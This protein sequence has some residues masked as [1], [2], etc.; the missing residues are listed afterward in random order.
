MFWYCHS[1]GWAASLP[2]DGSM[3][4]IVW[5]RDS[6]HVGAML[7]PTTLRGWPLSA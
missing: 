2:Y 1:H 6:R 5:E 4:P 3:A 7:S